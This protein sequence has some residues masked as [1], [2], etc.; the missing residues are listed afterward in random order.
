M[1]Q[2]PDRYR[3][4]LPLMGFLAAMLSLGER[5]RAYGSCGDYLSHSG[6]SV[7]SGRMEDGS[8]GEFPLRGEESSLP[9]RC[10]GPHCRSAPPSSPSPSP[11][12]VEVTR[13]DLLPI[14]T[15]TARLRSISVGH[16][17]F[18]AGIELPEPLGTRLERP[19]RAV[20]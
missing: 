15:M 13:L 9:G 16:D 3:R 18:L 1:F 11:V 19:P 20:A 10:R 12:R 14:E 7:E 6:S 5:N 17:Y 4:W 8:R 2:F